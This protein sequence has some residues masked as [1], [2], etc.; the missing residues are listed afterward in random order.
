VTSDREDRDA[1][2]TVNELIER[3]SLG[4]AGAQ[5]LRERV[6][7]AEARSIRKLAVL[8]D[9]ARGV[10][11]LATTG[12]PGRSAEP[13]APSHESKARQKE[14][15]PLLTPAQVATM[16][17]VD[18][19]TVT[20]WAKRGRLTSIR[21]VGGHRRYRE[22]EVRELLRALPPPSHRDSSPIVGEVPPV[23]E[24]AADP[25]VGPPEATAIGNDP[26]ESV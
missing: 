7:Q 10:E 20:R 6:S 13:D 3:S 23:P 14:A 16:F 5:Q 1:A 12:T 18:P 2:T 26:Q 4:T 22:T 15:E 24:T 8:R 11:D 19:K 9:A 17:H 25:R 21:T